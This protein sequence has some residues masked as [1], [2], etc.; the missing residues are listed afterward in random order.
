MPDGLPDFKIGDRIKVT[1]TWEGAVTKVAGGYIE[2]DNGH[3]PSLTVNTDYE[4]GHC[5]VTVEVIEPAYEDDAVYM[6]ADGDIVVRRDDGRWDAVGYDY[7]QDEIWVTRPL[8]KLVPEN[9]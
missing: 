9:G 8:V 2:L 3:R 1:R 6:D 5:A 4:T 7:P